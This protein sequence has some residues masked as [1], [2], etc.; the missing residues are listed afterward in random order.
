MLINFF[1]GTSALIN[2]VDVCKSVKVLP[3]CNATKNVAQS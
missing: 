2:T 1:H 3:H